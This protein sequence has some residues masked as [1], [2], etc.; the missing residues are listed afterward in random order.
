MENPKISLKLKIIILLASKIS[1]LRFLANNILRKKFLEF[2]EEEISGLGIYEII[3]SNILAIN[4]FDYQ[5][6]NFIYKFSH[7]IRGYYSINLVVFMNS[8]DVSIHRAEGEI[9]FTYL[10]FEKRYDFCIG[11]DD[12]K[13]FVDILRSFNRL[14][15][16]LNSYGEVI[17][18][19][20]ITGPNTLIK[21]EKG[22]SKIS[23]F[24][25]SYFLGLDRMTYKGTWKDNIAKK[26]IRGA[27]IQMNNMLCNME[28]LLCDIDT[29]IL[30][31]K[32]YLITKYDK[33]SHTIR[34]MFCDIIIAV[35]GS[36]R[37]IQEFAFH[38]RESIKRTI[39][40]GVVIAKFGGIC[41][42]V[43]KEASFDNIYPV[44]TDIMQNKKYILG[45]AEIEE[46]K[47]DKI[48]S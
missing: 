27:K 14:E 5:D 36:N 28:K 13:E 30:N 11:F 10:K 33:G 18:N 29:E 9:K 24:E 15:N 34:I 42:P 35:L 6:E 32:K 44:F 19:I 38:A 20:K 43:F 4:V 31:G 47:S 48:Q 21:D 12:T 2:I 46:V 3:K 45:N 17:E 8:N 7:I 37:E 1:F 41:I 26:K 25:I 16:Y 22:R 23:E 39:D 40:K